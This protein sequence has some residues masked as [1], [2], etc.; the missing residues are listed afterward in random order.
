MSSLGR[1]GIARHRRILGD[2]STGEMILVDGATTADGDICLSDISVSD[3][4][5]YEYRKGE[6]IDA[7]YTGGSD[8]SDDE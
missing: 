8:I 7:T 3:Y 4:E 6:T 5:S 1:I 2:A